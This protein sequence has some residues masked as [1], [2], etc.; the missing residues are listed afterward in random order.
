M[1]IIVE[2]TSVESICWKTWLL[3][4]LNDMNLLWL[5]KDVDF[6][7]WW[8]I[9]IY[10]DMMIW[11]CYDFWYVSNTGVLYVYICIYVKY[12]Q[13]IWIRCDT[14]IYLLPIMWTVYDTWIYMLNK[15]DC[16][17]CRKICTCYDLG[18]VVIVTCMTRYLMNYITV[19]VICVIS[20]HTVK[21]IYRKR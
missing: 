7:L 18:I 2:L 11:N 19:H 9:W 4:M 8:K 16:G 6:Y 3:Y 15:V 21:M 5:L 12:V 17:I 14:W 1:L 20:R 13:L 10:Y